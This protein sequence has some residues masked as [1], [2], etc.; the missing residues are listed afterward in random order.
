MNQRFATLTPEIADDWDKLVLDSPDGWAFSLSGWQRLIMAVEEWQLRDHSFALY[1]NNQIVSVM[2]LQSSAHSRQAASSGWGGSGPIVAKNVS[3]A[4]RDRVLQRTLDHARDIAQSN[5][6]STLEFTL[7][8]VTRTSIAARWGVNPFVHMGF[9]DKSQISQVIDLLPSEAALHES[10]DPDCRRLLRRSEEAGIEVRQVDWLEYLDQYYA[11]HQDTYVRTGVSP[12]PKEYFSSL[13]R[14]MAPPGHA[15][16]FAAFTPAGEAIAFV[17]TAR[18]GIGATYHTGCSQQAALRNGANY[19]ALWHAIL[20]AKR[21][22]YRWFDVGPIFPHTDVPKLKG[23]TDFKT[24]FGG[25]PHRFFRCEMALPAA[26]ENTGAPTD[27]HIMDLTFQE[28]HAQPW[29]RFL[30]RPRQILRR[31]LGWRGR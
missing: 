26:G 3:A 10:L 6:A 28:A 23:L 11:L 4:E 1:E 18:F 25:E 2:P 20:S 24:K 5:G 21:D 13:A 30:R 17:N 15:V 27:A 7:S 22:G 14:Y 12:H 31:A 8:P 29:R 16:L 9:E 19:S